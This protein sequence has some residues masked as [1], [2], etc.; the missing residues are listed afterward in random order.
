MY[1][2][3]YIYRY[4]DDRAR[5]AE[6]RFCVCFQS[7]MVVSEEVSGPSVFVQ[8]VAELVSEEVSALPSATP[9]F[10]ALPMGHGPV[11]IRE[12]CGVF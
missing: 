11:G 7:C 8:D 3:I 10:L 6:L 1:V 9:C 4:T 12:R 5:R 2:Y